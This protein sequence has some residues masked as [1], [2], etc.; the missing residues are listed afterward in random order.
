MATVP[1]RTPQDTP[2]RASFPVLPES[3]GMQL[4]TVSLIS[5]G[6]V[7]SVAFR[8]IKGALT[9]VARCLR[10]CSQPAYYPGIHFAGG[11]VW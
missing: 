8:L 3:V 11:D 4:Y 9:L 10:L 2:Q 1:Q 6:K 5:S 7:K